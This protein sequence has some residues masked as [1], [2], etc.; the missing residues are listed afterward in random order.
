MPA[1]VVQGAPPW[2]GSYE[3]ESFAFTNRE[4]HKIKLLSGIRAGE[5]IEALDANDTAAYVGVA[6]V[7]L[8]R[9]DVRLD[10]D[11]LW[12]APVG[13]VRIDLGDVGDPPTT[14]AVEGEPSERTTSSGSDSET[15]GV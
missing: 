10:P 11:D 12:N 4:L 14:P 2:D 8:E 7:V 1:L 9:H 5:L 6:V 3:F 15:G 13:S